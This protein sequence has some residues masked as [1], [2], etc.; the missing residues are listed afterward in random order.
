MTKKTIITIFFSAVM[1]FVLCGCSG[2]GIMDTYWRDNKTGE[3]LIG[4]VENKVIYDCKLWGFS[5]ME[6]NDG[7]YSLRAKYGTDS[8]DISFGS[9]QDGKRI[10]TIGEKQY[11]CSLIEG[12][13]LPDYPEKDTTAFANNH[14]AVGDSVTIEHYLNVH[15]WPTYKLFDRNG[16]LLDL[17][18]DARDLEGLA[19]LLE[20]MK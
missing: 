1:A 17:K 6:E 7:T 11:D 10:I 18:V 4:I 15:S 14:Y 3:W 20:K 13:Y 19:G 8:L 16:N 9:E 5:K 12:R 2:G